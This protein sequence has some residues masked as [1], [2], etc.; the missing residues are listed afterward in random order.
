MTKANNPLL[1][2]GTTISVKE[3]QA[4]HTTTLTAFVAAIAILWAGSAQ[5]Q[6]YSTVHDD[7]AKEEQYEDRTVVITNICEEAINYVAFFSQD[8][9]GYVMYE[10][11][12]T[13]KP[14]EKLE[15]YAIGEYGTYA[16][17]VSDTERCK[18]LLGEAE[19]SKSWPS[20]QGWEIREFK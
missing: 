2:L 17:R 5:S 15:Y 14:G 1:A 16:C 4:M 8:P 3:S 10:V 7:C 12:R 18:E 6:V 20:M 13:L 11:K 19:E 9:V